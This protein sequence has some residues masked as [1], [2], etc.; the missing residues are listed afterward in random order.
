MEYGN[1]DQFP[2]KVS[3][4]NASGLSEAFFG[5]SIYGIN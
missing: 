3:T 5:I 4:K 2:Y 1:R